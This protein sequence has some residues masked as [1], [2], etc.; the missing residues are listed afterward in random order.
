LVGRITDDFTFR[1]REMIGGSIELAR[2]A[3][4]RDDTELIKGTLA[5]ACISLANHF[6][7]SSLGGH[8]QRSNSGV[9]D[10]HFVL[11][12]SAWSL[13][14]GMGIDDLIPS[15]TCRFCPSR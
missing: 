6:I 2:V 12:I 9:G 7:P 1:K 10:I 4:P 13:I 11:H 14:I 5:A 3:E 15:L 8:V